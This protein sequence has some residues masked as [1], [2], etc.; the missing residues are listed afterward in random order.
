MTLRQIYS[1]E[2]NRLIIDLPENF[3]DRKSFIVLLKDVNNNFKYI[4]L[5]NI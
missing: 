4:H 1:V 3:Q 5:E 2:N